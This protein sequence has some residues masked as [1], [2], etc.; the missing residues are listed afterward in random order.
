MY[1]FC[2]DNE[3]TVERGI[4]SKANHSQSLQHVPNATARAHNHYH[5]FKVTVQQSLC[6]RV[7]KIKRRTRYD[8]SC[9][10]AKNSKDW[11]GGGIVLTCLLHPYIWHL[12]VSLID[13]F[14][15]YG[16]QYFYF[17]LWLEV[18]DWIFCLFVFWPKCNS[19]SSIPFGVWPR[20]I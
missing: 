10:A 3:S 6:D 15:A 5:S 1:I 4:F 19:S 13:S 2:V 7:L 11:A 17:W 14:L 8:D 16:A 12:A 20:A 18:N 9:S